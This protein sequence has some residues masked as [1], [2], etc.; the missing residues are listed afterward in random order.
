MRV[1]S[2]YEYH[3]SIKGSIGLKISGPG[4]DFAVAGSE[5]LKIANED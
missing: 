4:L 3:Q 5:V 2:E 1:K